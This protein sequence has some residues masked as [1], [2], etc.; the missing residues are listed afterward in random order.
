MVD[1]AGVQAGFAKLSYHSIQLMSLILNPQSSAAI[2]GDN[3]STNIPSANIATLHVASSR[4]IEITAFF[5]A[6]SLS[7]FELNVAVRSRSQAHHVTH[8]RRF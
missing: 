8:H 5:I 3:N 1:G 7:Q 4:V 2:N 6:V